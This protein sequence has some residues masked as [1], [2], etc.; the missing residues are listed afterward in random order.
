M[1]KRD[2]DS[3]KPPPR[4]ITA[5][6]VA[7]IAARKGKATS[8]RASQFT[9]RGTSSPRSI[10]EAAASNKRGRSAPSRTEPRSQAR[11]I[12]PNINWRLWNQQTTQPPVG[13]QQTPQ[14]PQ[15]P[16][17]SIFENRTPPKWYDA[18]GNGYWNDPIPPGWQPSYSGE[19]PPGWQTGVTGIGGPPLWTEIPPNMPDWW[20]YTGPMY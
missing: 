6:D 12:R 16:R 8:N 18:N 15:A 2:T 20:Q 4:Q 5:R 10:A 19:L 14:A 1:S 11:E 17:P 3:S 13:N 9:P 7:E